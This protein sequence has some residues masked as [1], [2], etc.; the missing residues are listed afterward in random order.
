MKSAESELNIPIVIPT[1]KSSI[2]YNKNDGTIYGIADFV[3]QRNEVPI[4]YKFGDDGNGSKVSR[5]QVPEEYWSWDVEYPEYNP[6]DFTY[7]T[8]GYHNITDVNK[9]TDVDYREFGKGDENGH[10]MRGGW[11][12]PHDIYDVV[13]AGIIE[14]R[15]VTCSTYDEIMWCRNELNSCMKK[16]NRDQEEKEDEKE[17]KERFRICISNLNAKCVDYG[18]KLR[19]SYTGDYK[20]YTDENNVKWPLNPM[21]RTGIKGRGA[22]G[23]WGPNHAADP[24]VCRKDPNTNKLQFVLIL[25]KDGGGWGLPGGMVESGDTISNTRTKEFA[26]EALGILEERSDESRSKII[27]QINTIFNKEPSGD[28]I[29]YQGPCD[30]DRNTDNSWMETVAILT[31]LDNEQSTM[32][33]LKAGDDAKG[34]RWTNYNEDM[35]LFA[36][37]KLFVDLAVQKLKDRELIRASGNGEYEF[38]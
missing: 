11:A 31:I 35:V 4:Y 7:Y 37:H 25:R 38:V 26:E 17:E 5:F 8:V 9:G 16:R 34:V 1:Y 3:K 32:L 27:E 18:I 10:V 14:K 15:K 28:D 36:S 33:N 12:D 22:L 30:D 21:G 24:V 23:N 13:Q 20:F 19:F 2:N 6:T 29:L